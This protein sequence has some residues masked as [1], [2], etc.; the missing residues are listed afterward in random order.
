MNAASFE[1]VGLPVDEW[2]VVDVV[3]CASFTFL[4]FDFRQ[5]LKKLPLS[6]VL[7]PFGL[8]KIKI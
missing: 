5:T 4:P 1:L 2:K 3:I 8:S 7:L 6:L